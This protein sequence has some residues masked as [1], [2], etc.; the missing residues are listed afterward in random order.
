[1]TCK[2]QHDLDIHPNLSGVTEVI[3]NTERLKVVAVRF[4][5]AGKK[6]FFDPR[7]FELQI[8]DHV[9]V[10]TA[11]GIEYGEVVSHIKEVPKEDVY[12]PIKPILR[13][14][15]D[16]DTEKHLQNKSEEPGILAIT[17]E[18][19]KKNGLNMRLLACE[20]TFDRSKLIIYFSAETRVDFRQLVK[21]LAAV[22]KTRIELRQVGVRDEAKYVGGIGPCGRILCCTTFLGHFD[23]VSIKMAKN[24]HLSLN[25][26]KI[27]GACGKLLCCI[28]YE[29]EFYE[30]M[31]DIMPDIGEII[32]TP[33]GEGKVIGLNALIET[34]KVMLSETN[35]MR[36]YHLEEIKRIE[37]TDDEEEFIDEE[38]RLLEDEEALEEKNY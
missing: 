7:D 30:E 37:P 8:G 24:Q 15:T 26:Q 35:A 6:Y 25:P 9:L 13:K 1:M 36:T 12:L 22:F 31:K 19:V 11:R 2:Y 10:E 17:E 21:D 4:K 27:S 38:L 3:P 34:V 29:A 32:A 16:E 28:R 18:L 14:A 5:P 23:S 20:Y 33:D